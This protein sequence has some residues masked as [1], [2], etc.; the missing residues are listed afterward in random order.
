MSGK[1]IL[2]LTIGMP[3]LDQGGSG[4]FNYLVIKHLIKNNY[5][6]KAIF[7]ASN[8]FIKNN[9]NLN[10]LADLTNIGLDFEIINNDERIL[11]KLL[12]LGLY[13]LPFGIKYL[14]LIADADICE[15]YF[16]QINLNDYNFAITQGLGW[17]IS[18]QGK[19]IKSLS[20]LPDDIKQKTKFLLIRDIKNKKIY[21][22]EFFTNLYTYLNL[23]L[24]YNQ[25]T[26]LFNSNEN[27]IGSFSPYSVSQ[28]IDMGVIC[29]HYSWF[30]PIPVRKE[31]IQ[32]ITK[33]KNEIKIL[34][35]GS[36]ESNAGK[37]FIEGMKL[38]NNSLESIN[39]KIKYEIIGKSSIRTQIDSTK[40]GLLE[41]HYLGFINN[42]EPH[43]KNAD[44][45]VVPNNYP[46][47]VRTRILTGISYGLIVIAHR[48]SSYGLPE[49]IP[50]KE[51]FYFSDQLDFSHLL[52]YLFSDKFNLEKYKSYAYSAWYKYYNPDNN[53]NELINAVNN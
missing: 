44:F 49:L 42:I 7:L 4:I 51:I 24:A 33:K 46:V 27:L 47:G 52:G 48:S 43:L 53:I 34:S 36:L 12:R 31:E 38:I 45:L 9:I 6:V 37:S 22:K 32:T 39:K 20:I 2:L 25:F 23:I 11:N 41:I 21:T 30:T 3:D 10:Y 29:K 16:K 15:N 18:I 8:S 13:K 28:Y 14:K 26:K 5:K 50:G 17:A 19:K 40:Q 35:L 1:K